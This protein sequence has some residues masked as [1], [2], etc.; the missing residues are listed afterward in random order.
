MHRDL[1]TCFSAFQKYV[2][3]QA[4]LTR[5]GGGAHFS[6]PL[7]Q[8]EI[9]QGFLLPE[10]KDRVSTCCHRRILHIE[11]NRMGSWIIFQHVQQDS[12]L[13]NTLRQQDSCSFSGAEQAPWHTQLSILPTLALLT[14]SPGTCLL[15]PQT[16]CLSRVEHAHTSRLLECVARVGRLSACSL[17]QDLGAFQSI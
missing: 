17:G 2:F 11:G 8:A 5:F 16:R 13:P 10:V 9:A 1:P 6:A 3:R 7:L 14:A 4:N 15:P 12:A